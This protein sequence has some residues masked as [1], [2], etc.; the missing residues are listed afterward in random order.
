MANSEDI[1]GISAQI[2]IS[3]IQETLDKLCNK[4]QE[5]GTDT[6]KLSERTNKALN[7]IAKSDDDFSRKTQQA[8]DVL[9]SAMDE[10]AK[11]MSEQS[12]HIKEAEKRVEKYQSAIEKLNAELANTS[13]GNDR[14]S[15][16]QRQLAAQNEA[17]KIEKDDLNDLIHARN[18]LSEAISETAGAYKALG[19]I[20]TASAAS[21]QVQAATN[22]EITA[23]A[24]AAAA[25]VGIEAAAHGA[26]AASASASASA[27]NEAAAATSNLSNALKEY[28]STAQGRLDIER[29]QGESAKELKE[30]IK[31]YSQAIKEIEQTIAESNID[32]KISDATAKIERQ[33]QEIQDL[34]QWYK[35]L[36]SEAQSDPINKGLFDFKTES[37]ENKIKSLQEYIESLRDSQATLN[38]DLEQ[39][40]ALLEAAQQ[41]AS[42]QAV[43]GGQEGN[44]A[45]DIQAMSMQQLQE[46]LKKSK[47]ELGSLL[48]QQEELKRSDSYSS[49]SE[50]AKKLEQQIERTRERQEALNKELNKK[51]GGN[52]WE[53][54]R[55]GIQGVT[56]EV[57]SLNGAL[58]SGMAMGAKGLPGILS[59]LTSIAAAGGPAGAAITA[60]VVALGAGV[61]TLKELTAQAEK[62]HLAMNKLK[63]YVDDDTL[64]KLREG[65]IQ[66]ALQ[67]SAQSTDDMAAAASRWVRYYES[68]RNAPKSVQELVDASRDLATLTGQT[69]DSATEKLTKMAGEYHLT[70]L[71]AKNMVNVLAN[72]SKSSTVSIEEMATALLSSGQRA[73]QMGTSFSEMA[74][75]VSMSSQ[76]FPSAS[77]AASSYLMVLQRLSNQT[78]KE[79]NPLVVGSVKALEN[80]NKAQLTGKEIQKM[81][82]VRIANQAR[83]FIQN[84][85]AIA[86]YENGLDSATG[87]QKALTRQQETAEYNQKAL[88]N[89]MAALAQEININLT[90]GLV[91]LI[92]GLVRMINICSQG[93]KAAKDF[94]SPFLEWLEKINDAIESSPLLKGMWSAYKNVASSQL[95]VGGKFLNQVVSLGTQAVEDNKKTEELR[96][97]AE[98]AYSAILK[99]NPSATSEEILKEVKRKLEDKGKGSKYKSFYD[100]NLDQIAEE[101]VSANEAMRIAEIKGYNPKPSEENAIVDTEASKKTEQVAKQRF[102][103]EQENAQIELQ[104]ANQL[105]Q[106]KIDAMEE[107]AKKQRMQSELDHKKRLQQ[108]RQQAQQY[109]N[110]NIEALA[111]EYARNNPNGEGFYSSGRTSKVEIKGIENA[112]DTI[113]NPQGQSIGLNTAQSNL[114]DSL[115]KSEDL[116]YVKEQKELYK[117]LIESHQSFTDQKLAIDRK[118]EEERAAIDSAIAQAQE[119]KDYNTASALSRSRDQ[120]DL[121]YNN[122]KAQLSFQNISAGIDWKSLLS[123]INNLSAQMLKPMLEQLQ[124]YVKTDEYAKADIQTQKG[125]ADLIEEIRQYIGPDESESRETDTQAVIDATTNFFKALEDF[126][127]AR[128]KE[129]V[130]NAELAKAKESYDKGEITSDQYNKAEQTATEAAYVTEKSRRDV[131]KFGNELN[132]ASDKL[133]N[134]TSG[135]SASLE[136]I[137]TWGGV[138]GIGDLKNF[139]VRADNMA[140]QLRD[141]ITKTDEKGNQLMS[142]EEGKTANQLASGVEKTL[143]AMGDGIESLLSSGIGQIVGFVAQIPQLVLQI[144]DIIKNVVTGV[145]NSITTLLEFEWLDDLVNSILAAIENLINAIFDLPENLYHAL[146]S[147]VVNGVGGLLDTILGR[148]GN[149]LSLGAL[150]SDGPSSW[151]TNSNAKKVAETIERLTERNKLLQTSID[152]LNDT[153]KSY[154]GSTAIDATR[155]AIT[156]QEE[157]NQNYLDIAKAQA[158]YHESHHSWNKYWSGFTQEEI[159]RL[160]EQFKGAGLDYG[161]T[162]SLWDLSPEQMKV[163][164]SNIDIWERILDTGKGD[165]GD[166]LGEKL[167]DYIEQAGK[168]EELKDQLIETLT[169]TSKEGIFDDFLDSLYKLASG[170]KDVFNDVSSSWQEM[171]NKMVVDNIIGNQFQERLNQWITDLSKLQE[172]KI[173]GLSDAEYKRRLEEL[174][175][176]RTDMLKEAA[177][178]VDY[179]RQ[180]GIIQSTGNYEQSASAKGVSEI[181]YDQA[182]NLTGLATARNI[183]LEQGNQIRQVIQIDTT[184]LRVTAMQIQSDV[185][186]IRDIQEQGLNQLTRIEVNTRPINDILL[187]CN[188]MYRLQKEN[189]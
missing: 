158:S 81:F 170:S 159:D 169:G 189:S 19:S 50:E 64:G 13:K 142:T 150:S 108:I 160:N 52:G 44:N 5:V 42:G 140:K 100:S 156:L 102:K 11:S 120:L 9:K 10:A 136:N 27:N 65:F 186:V 29:M 67:G 152:D 1:L 128:D 46:E 180:Q 79:Y 59:S 94:F 185:S 101:I 181:T 83:Y 24:G 132:N 14:Y 6:E 168:L 39:Y 4:L 178:S 166:R 104:L 125:I 122:T 36:S 90:P 106:N 78:K 118:Y 80:L 82:G 69:A 99:E 37:A 157:T 167:D 175:E 162:G 103:K 92:N 124:A 111:I 62:L 20:Q 75:V 61:V 40:N 123:G 43:V 149:V 7:D 148:V 35:S 73:K 134:W 12:A 129:D 174:Q 163:L 98:D 117:Q 30:E 3:N 17:L 141:A 63:A 188:E 165:Y 171:V 154:K 153:I 18:G 41:I 84:A 71:E 28:I 144:A 114:I 85:D 107:G 110:A 70:A 119:D 51:S 87:K 161:W 133:K 139:S 21:G 68:L 146:E 32:G 135:L 127:T 22:V 72:A 34:K 55:K 25:A 31:L 49:Q 89:A 16:V 130:A 45:T 105:E 151:F 173:G 155:R 74:A 109:V 138:N 179:Y 176:Q 53:G 56:K 183:I 95:G 77:A 121:D 33:K 116:S 47:E 184:Q 60:V 115:I 172:D 57:K 187:V 26:N 177:E 88:K 145:L 76:N 48:Q 126:N 96:A 143:G 58:N 54:A 182:N 91:I 112:I 66:A 164:R 113:T 86:K 15:E 38:G 131:Q 137:G 23:T 147:I 8:M 2:D 93:A 97:A